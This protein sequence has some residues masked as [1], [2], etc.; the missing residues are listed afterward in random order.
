M[1]QTFEKLGGTIGSV[2]DR[3][4]EAY[5]DSFS[6]GGDVLRILYPDGIE[7]AR[8][9]DVL[10]IARV[11]DKLFRIANDPMAFGEDPWMDIAGYGLL[12]VMAR[13]PSDSELTSEGLDQ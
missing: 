5:G 7:T 1:S 6:K 2:V 8:Y 11:V 12:G 13:R 10:A 4:N 3:K 9:G